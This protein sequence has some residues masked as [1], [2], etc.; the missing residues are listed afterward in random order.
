MRLLFLLL[1][2]LGAM[3]SAFAHKASDSYLSLQAEGREIRGQWDIALRDLDAAIGLDANGDGEIRWGEVRAAQHR[4][5]TYALSHLTIRGDGEACTLSAVEH[6]IDHHSDGAYAVM[7]LR[8]SCARDVGR[9]AVDYR[10]LFDVDAQ[11]RGLLKLSA[12]GTTV[13]AV[14]PADRPLQTFRVG[15][16]G[17]W[18][19]LTGF[20]RDGIRHI[21]AGFD[22]ILF[23][24]ALLL[25]AVL[26]RDKQ[27]GSTW[28]PVTTLPAAL[29]NV[30]KIVTAFTLAHSITL[31]LATLG[32]VK[33]PSR[34]IEALIAAS[35]VATAVDNLWPF[36]P[37]RRW[38]IA[39]AFGLVHGF[40]FAT[41]LLDLDLSRTGLAVSLFGFNLGVEIGQLMLVML[42]VPL[43][44]LA[45]ERR[46]YPHLVVGAGSSLIAVVALGWLVERSFRLQFM[47]F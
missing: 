43:A 10:L 7:R 21:A 5:A 27:R 31:S 47:P 30:A 44:Y 4:I 29:W 25:P 35:V 45:R 20:V 13:S 38:L 41:V 42:V 36:L 46:A 24:I 34:A 32:L 28:L 17:T 12:G 14:F 6:L 37:A 18:A 3:P 9:L 1:V 2:L 39:F 8:G 26:V 40:G 15:E 11:H 22:H 33:V 16:A 19:Q 23:L